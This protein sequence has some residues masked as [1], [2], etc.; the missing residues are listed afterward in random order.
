MS[1]NL[2]ETNAGSGGAKL[3]VSQWTDGANT[4][5]M[6]LS[7]I[8]FSVIDT[9]AVMVSASNPFPVV[10]TGAL[11]AGTAMIGHMI[12]DTGSTVVVTGISGTVSLPTGAS[13]A[14]LQTTGNTSLASVDG[15]IPAQGQALAAASMPVVLTAAQMTTLTPP[16]AITGFATAANQSTE[17]TSL[18]LIDDAVSGAGFNITQLNG[19]N[20]TMGNGVS[21]T[22]VQRV[23]I[24]SDSTGTLALAASSAVIGH[25]IVDSGTLTTCSTV[26]NLSQLGG[27]A[28]AMN[29]GVRSTGTQRVTI[30]TD[31]VVPASQSGT[32]TVQPGNTANTTAWKVD[33]S[34]VTQPVSLASVPSHAVTVA[35]A[36]TGGFTPYNLISANTTNATNVKASSGTVYLLTAMNN[37]ATICYLKVYNKASAPTVGSDTPV[38]ILMLPATGGVSVPLPPIGIAFGTGISFALTTNLVNSDTTAVAANQVTVNLG[39]A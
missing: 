21:G 36:T 11:P 38:L 18:Q 35:S 6:P 31:D 7:G 5:R 2:V 33:G 22:G 4:V 12:A 19:V 32:W 14:A 3:P 20:V 16:A 26:T 1:I 15:K 23:T 27:V 39:Y 29:T 25:T 30:A 9:A 13:T 34:A 37:A 28:I 8:G 10:Q 24:A 17:I